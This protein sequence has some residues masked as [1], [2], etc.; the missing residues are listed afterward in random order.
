MQTIWQAWKLCSKIFFIVNVP[1]IKIVVARTNI[2][3][4]KLTAT[5]SLIQETLQDHEQ[6]WVITDLESSRP[7]QT[8]PYQHLHAPEWI[9]QNLLQLD[10]IGI[11]WHQWSRWTVESMW[12]KKRKLLWWMI[13]EMGQR[14]NRVLHGR[15]RSAQ[16]FSLP[17][18]YT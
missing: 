15:E 11:N 1:I 16:P 2:C 3:I 12:R 17:V 4:S 14:K 13:R 10:G 6:V 7:F 9:E 18:D 5:F 8:M